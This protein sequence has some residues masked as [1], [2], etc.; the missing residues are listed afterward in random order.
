[1][2][3]LRIAKWDAFYKYGSF[4]KIERLRPMI[5]ESRFYFASP[6][7]LNDPSDCKNMVQDHS[8]EE[9]QE[10]LIE[11]NRLFYG[12]SR[13]DAY[14]KEGIRNF[15]AVTL[16]EEMTKQ[17]NKIMDT[18]YGVFSL[19][20]RPDNMA[21]WA[22]YADN[23]KGY[24]LEFSDLSSFSYVYK[25]HY[26]EK[27]PLKLI[28]NIDPSQA[29]FLFTKS[30]EWSNEEEAR[31]L[32]KPHGYHVLPRNALKGIILGEHCEDE[33]QDVIIDWI[34]E[35]NTD[36]VLKKAK[37]NIA[38]QKLEFLTMVST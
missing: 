26:S 10:F 34:K 36:I 18:R 19:A 29:D 31:I 32:S 33:N 8:E 15:G 24:C 14:I 9:I 37:F 17:F 20:K 11:A 22:K 30:P 21:L 16:L 28:L 4:S 25:V 38:K 2:T 35:C 13:G 12:D 23:H 1:M 6:S 7:Q 5:C 27:I 3:Q